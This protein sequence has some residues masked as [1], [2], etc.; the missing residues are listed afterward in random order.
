VFTA[1]EEPSSSPRSGF[2]AGLFASDGGVPKYPLH[3]ALVSLD[4]VAG[5]RQRNLKYHG[6]RDRAL[7]LYSAEAIEALR[8]EGHPLGPGTLGE[9]VLVAGLRWNDVSPGSRL[10]LGDVTVEITDYTKP[11][12]TIAQSFLG[13]RIGRVSQRTHPG[14][15]RVYARVL[16]DGVIRVG[17]PV[18]LVQTSIASSEG[19]AQ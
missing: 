10:E 14:W 4:G 5:D 6:G 18:R 2:I 12:R 16:A 11:C 13:A 7:C 8:A 3:E 9:N 15:S 1:L 19:S 17:D